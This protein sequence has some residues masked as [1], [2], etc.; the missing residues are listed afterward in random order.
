MKRKWESL[1]GGNSS[2]SDRSFM[3]IRFSVMLD[4]DLIKIGSIYEVE[5][6]DGQ[7]ASMNTVL[8]GCTLNLVDH[9]LKSI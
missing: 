6:A 9:I 3:D 4:I 8:K 1:Q 7:V 2:G 5:L